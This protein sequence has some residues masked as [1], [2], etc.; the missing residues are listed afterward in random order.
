MVKEK[1]ELSKYYYHGVSH[2]IGIDT[3][4]VGSNQQPLK[5]GN[6]IT[7]EPGLYVAEKNIGIRLENDI[8]ITAGGCKNLSEHIPIE[9]DEIEQLM[10]KRK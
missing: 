10:N 2:Y 8:L 7:V 4:D 1:T 5:K 6:V 3:H 9:A